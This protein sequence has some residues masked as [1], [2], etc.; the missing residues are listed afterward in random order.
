MPDFIYTSAGSI[1]SAEAECG[2]DEQKVQPPWRPI[3]AAEPAVGLPLRNID[4]T[5]DN[6]M[7]RHT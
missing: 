1:A 5:V 4:V 2:T 6:L 3:E 7:T